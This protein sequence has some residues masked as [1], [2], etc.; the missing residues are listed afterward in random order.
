MSAGSASACAGFSW[1]GGDADAYF[2]GLNFTE[3]EKF[4]WCL[5]R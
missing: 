1:T 3:G 2:G 4:Q 5:S